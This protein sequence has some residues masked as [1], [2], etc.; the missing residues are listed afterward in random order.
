MLLVEQLSGWQEGLEPANPGR[1][2]RRDRG[3]G[4]WTLG[5]GIGGCLEEVVVGEDR[6]G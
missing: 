6:R 3:L 4:H 5:G 1:A 2:G